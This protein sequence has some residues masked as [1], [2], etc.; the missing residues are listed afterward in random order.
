[1]QIPPINL[2]NLPRFSGSPDDIVYDLLEYL[3]GPN[4]LLQQMKNDPNFP[5]D[6]GT[7]GSGGWME[8]MDDLYSQLNSAV[9]TQLSAALK[10]GRITQAQ[11]NAA[12]KKLLGD[13]TD[14]TGGDLGHIFKPIYDLFAKKNPPPTK[15]DLNTLIT[16][17]T[18]VDGPIGKFYADYLDSFPPSR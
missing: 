7:G 3:E 11:Y 16:Q 1:M 17:L 13:A 9:I 5:A 12:S 4:G 2:A 10:S 6:I 14:P 8:K 18:G 15:D